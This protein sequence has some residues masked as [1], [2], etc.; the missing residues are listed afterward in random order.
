[1]SSHLRGIVTRRWLALN[2]ETF[3]V[4][5]V[6][7]GLSMG[8][9]MPLSRATIGDLVLPRERGKYQGG[10]EPHGVARQTT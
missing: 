7:E 2:L 9:M 6:L 4:A 3:M 5:R 1:M 8:T 10:K